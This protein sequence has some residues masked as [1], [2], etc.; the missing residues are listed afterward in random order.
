MIIGVL[1]SDVTDLGMDEVYIRDTT[2]GPPFGGI[3]YPAS[4]DKMVDLIEVNTYDMVKKYTFETF[5][6]EFKVIIDDAIMSSPQH[7]KNLENR[8]LL[9]RVGEIGEGDSVQR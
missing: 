7:Q 3:Y 5:L 9:E 6:S 8:G 1:R 4:Y 2:F